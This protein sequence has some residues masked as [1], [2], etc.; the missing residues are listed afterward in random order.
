MFPFCFCVAILSAQA[1]GYKFNFGSDVPQN[2]FIGVDAKQVYSEETGYGF[3]YNSQM[4]LMKAKGGKGIYKQFCTNDSPFYFSVKLPEGNYRVIVH[5]GNKN[6]QSLTTV[7]AESRKLILEK[8][9]TDHDTPAYSFLVNVNTT[10]VDSSTTVRLKPRDRKSLTWDHKLTLEFCDRQ[11]CIC[12]VEIEKIDKPLTVYLAGNSTVTDQ[13]EEPWAAWGQMIPR[14]FKNDVVVANYAESGA[15]LPS[16]VSSNRLKKILNLIQ[17]G[18]Y[19]FIEFGHNDQKIKGENNGAYGAYSDYLRMFVD[20]ARK[21]GATPV[22]V[23]SMHRRSFDEQGKVINTLG[24]FPDAMR[25]VAQEKKVN[26]IDLNAMSAKLYEA[27]GPD[28]SVKAFCH[29]P[30]HTYP[31]QTEALKDNTHFNNYGA[32]HIALC[33]LQGIVDNGLELADHIRKDFEGF[34]PEKPIP[35]DQ[36]SFP[37]SLFKSNQKPDG[38]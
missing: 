15:S 31:N 26:L 2:G 3:D 38:N 22:L 35:F 37:E 19:L 28:S 1:Q 14:F 8:I 17:P 9:S 6:G 36:W 10:Y 21:K 13:N 27:W 32:Y 24:D 11:P 16:F 12:A 4:K 30:P 18:D 25:K 34:N 33:I 29:Y 7:K 5:L 23:T 20:E